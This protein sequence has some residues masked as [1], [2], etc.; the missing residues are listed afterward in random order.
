MEAGVVVCSVASAATWGGGGGLSSVISSP[1]PTSQGQVGNRVQSK[2]GRANA[3]LKT[4]GR[5]PGEVH[6][7]RQ[8]LTQLGR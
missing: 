8:S 6:G 4:G 3:A 2:Q 5:D 7:G 1:G